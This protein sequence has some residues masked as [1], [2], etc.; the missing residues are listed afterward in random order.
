LQPRNKKALRITG[1]DWASSFAQIGSGLPP[2]Q[3]MEQIHIVESITARW[4]LNT[5]SF[6]C[7]RTD[8]LALDCN[9]S[10]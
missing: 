8:D 10:V 2:D 9:G 7:Y 4:R 6:A 3:T 5:F 1:A